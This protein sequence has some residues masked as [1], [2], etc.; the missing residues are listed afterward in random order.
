M[1]IGTLIVGDEPIFLTEIALE[2]VY[3]YMNNIETNMIA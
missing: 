2:V 3:M 1:V